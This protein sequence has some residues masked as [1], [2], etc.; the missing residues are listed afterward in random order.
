MT[1]EKSIERRKLRIWAV[2]ASVGRADL[3]CQTIARYPLQS[4]PA[5][6]VL[7]VG[8]DPQDVAGLAEAC[9]GVEIVLSEKGLC[10]QRNAALRRLR[11]KCDVIVF[12][13]DD[14]LL[15]EHYLENLERHFAANSQ[16]VG[17]TGVLIADGAH[18]TPIDF[19]DGARMLDSGAA[20]PY[21]REEPIS[22]LYG[23]NMAFRTSATEGLQF[24]EALPLYGW[25]EDVDFSNQ[26]ARKG[27]MIRSPSLTGIHLGTSGGRQSGLRLGYS[28]VS[29]II[30]LLRKGTIDPWRGLSL[31]MRN[32]LMNCGRSLWPEPNIDRRGRLAGNFLA[33]AD[34]TRGRVDPGRIVS[35]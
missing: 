2:V 20:L 34:L 27:Q 5:D 13:D 29:N 8:S 16:L 10:K 3:L 1:P 6:G 33:L 23:C 9:P 7:V 11:E 4:R 12:F 26:V 19:A 21:G 17:L 18:T 31:M 14:F 32:I 15:E 30:Y 24:D 22:W 25:Q 35:L 28:Q